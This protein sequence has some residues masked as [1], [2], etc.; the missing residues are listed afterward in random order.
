M[1][2]LCQILPIDDFNKSLVGEWKCIGKEDITVSISD[3]IICN[4]IFN[5]SNRYTASARQLYLER[6]WTFDDAPH[7]WEA[8]D[9]SL[10]G[11]TLWIDKFWMGTMWVNIY[12]PILYDIALVRKKTTDIENL[13]LPNA[14]NQKTLHNGHLLI[15]RDGKTYDVLGMEVK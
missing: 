7:R 10:K 3:S 6:L 8:C 13:P 5:Q 1:E 2:R 15:L 9:Y 11:D 14:N 4:N 12:P